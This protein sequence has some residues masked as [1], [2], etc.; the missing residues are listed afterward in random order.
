MTGI[1]TIRLDAKWENDCQGKKDYDGNILSI[2]TRYW[3]TSGG[4]E[5]R[6]NGNIVWHDG[7]EDMKP[8]AI[9]YLRIRSREF[10]SNRILAKQEFEGESFEEISNQ[11]EEWAQCQMDK[12]VDALQKAFAKGE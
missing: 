3:P 12:A 11:V 4:F 7:I 2:S 5:V 6:H 8:S 1:K 9:S 10:N